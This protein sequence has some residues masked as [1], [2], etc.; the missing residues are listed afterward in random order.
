MQP[1]QSPTH[2]AA[3]HRAI[4]WANRVVHAVGTGVLVSVMVAAFAMA[5]P[6]TSRTDLMTNSNTSALSSHRV[7][8]TLVPGNPWSAGE[9][10]QV[11]FHEDEGRFAV[12]GAAIVPGDLAVN[13][14]TTRTIFNVTVGAADCTA[15]AGANDVAVGI[16]DATGTITYLACPSF[17]ASATG[18]TIRLDVGTVAGGTNRITNPAT[19]GHSI[20]D[21][22]AAAGDC[23]APTDDCRISVSIVDGNAVGVSANVNEGGGGDGGGVPPGDTTPPIISGIAATSI[24]A[25]SASIIWTTNESS[26]SVV[27]Y[28]V[29][30]AY[31]LTATAPA[32]LTS[33][34]VPLNDLTESTTYHFQVCSTDGANN[35]ACSGDNTFTT[36]DLTPPVITNVVV[37]SITETSATIS[38]STNEPS[39]SFVDFGIVAGPPYSTTQSDAASV[40]SHGIILNGLTPN[41]TYHFRVRSADAAGNESFTSDAIFTTNDQSAPIISGVAATSVTTTSAVIVWTTNEGADSRVDIGTTPAY[42]TVLTDPAPVTSHS[43]PVTGLTP[44]TTY[45]FKVR[46]VDGAGNVAD[47]ADFTFTTAT[48]APPILSA[49]SVVSITTTSATVQWT[50]D[51]PATSVVDYGLS[52]AYGAT[53]TDATLV[54]PHSRPLVGLTPSTTYH[55]RVRST[56]GFGQETVSGDLTFTTLADTTPPGPVTDFVATPGDTQ[57]L[58]TWTLPNTPDLAGVRIVR[59]TNGF[60]SSPLSGVVVFDGLGDTTID[61]GLTNGTRYFYAAYAFDGAGNFSSPVFVSATPNGQPLPTQSCTDTD[62]GLKYDTF[63]EVTTQN[64]TFPDLCV[65]AVTLEEQ[66]CDG[67]TRVV[68]THACGNGFACDGGRCVPEAFV[69]V[70][71]VCGNG[72]CEVDETSVSCVADCPVIPQQTE[73][74]V[75][76][77]T[78]DESERLLPADL[79]VYAARK[80]VRLPMLRDTVRSYPGLTLTVV[81]PDEQIP[82]PVRT[83]TINFGGRAFAMSETNSYEVDIPAPMDIGV[84]PAT[85]IVT[86]ED[87][88]TD[89]VDISIQIVPFPTVKASA[90]PVAGA[91]VELLSEANGYARWDAVP[92][93]QANPM[94]SRADGSFGFVI[95]AGTYKLR[96]TKSGFVTEETSA[97]TQESGVVTRS[98]TLIAL[99]DDTLVSQAGFVADVITQAVDNLRNDATLREQAEVVATPAVTVVA[100][101]N[102][103]AAGAATATLAPFLAYLLS[104]LSQPFVLIGRRRRTQWGVVYDA[105]TRLPVDLATVRLLDAVTGRVVRSMVTDRNGRYFFIVEAGTY[106]LQVVRAGFS[107]PSTVLAGV[108]ADQ[109]YSDIYHGER[110]VLTDSG[111]IMVNIPVDPVGREKNVRQLRWERFGRKAHKSIAIGAVAVALIVAVVFPSALSI[112]LLG[113]NILMLALSRRLGVLRAAK[114]WGVV[115]D[116]QG[117]PVGQVLARVFD[118]KFNKLLESQITDREGR[119]SFLVGGNTYVVTYQKSGFRDEQRGPLSPGVVMSRGQQ[120]RMIAVDVNMRRSA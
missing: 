30:A 59:D 70:G 15:S 2:H 9:T 19:A 104:L 29:T 88:A 34:S 68:Q 90:I 81:I 47:S 66:F 103:V 97:F 72:M 56:D 113:T 92:F 71:S 44:N 24:T 64:G 57:V 26:N 38:W 78:V 67:Q 61:T 74:P 108:K 99:P 62:G 95:P 23:S 45:H 107:F 114:N 33:H 17:A 58:L 8:F 6:V 102:V 101:A 100:V 39:N 1:L 36:L 98:V 35:T 49:I 112:G 48:P 73:I 93:N 82:R 32:F 69:P 25:S 27:H 120:Q 116:E 80:T 31:G 115:R 55:F 85:A 83:A 91:T 3:L 109:D 75:P 50:T 43:I 52:V 54:T 119:Y 5:S 105:V 18:A 40:T 16:N 96:V 13:D 21:I 4:R 65:T 111:T 84:Y 110:I 94:M 11:D 12:A 10:L 87:G 41:T 51:I 42:G 37:T 106:A 77:T 118:T 20:I 53:T 79:I 14:G 28:G 22:T 86:Y 63:G 76:P 117:K 7:Q 60:P 89:S 46:S